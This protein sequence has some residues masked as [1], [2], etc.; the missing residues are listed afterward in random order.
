VA[1]A[2]RLAEPGQRFLLVRMQRF[3]QMAIS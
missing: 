1:M 3:Q 2:D